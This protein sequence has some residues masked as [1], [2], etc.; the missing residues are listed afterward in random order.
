MIKSF[1]EFNKI[2]ES[3]LYYAPP[4]RQQL[5]ILKNK[6]ESS[7]KGGSDI[8]SKLLELEM[9]D[10]PTDITF[11]NSAEDVGYLT[12]HPM[13]KAIEKIRKTYSPGDDDSEDP[14]D[15]QNKPNKKYHDTIYNN[16]INGRTYMS[17][18]TGNKNAVKIGKFIKK[19][20][21]TTT[22][23]Q[24][25]E[26]VN[27]LKA[28]QD[29]LKEKIEL[30]S[31]DEIAKWY[32]SENCYSGGSLGSSCMKDKN[33]FD[34]YI[35]NPETVNL[36]IM[37]S[38]DKIVSRALVWKLKTTKPQL[39]FTYYMDRVYTNKDYQEYV[40]MAFAEKQGWAYRKSGGVYE[41]DVM[42]QGKKH[43][44]K[45]SVQIKKLKYEKYPYMDTFSRYDYVTGE[46][47]NDMNKN[48]R[49]RGHILTSTQGDFNKG[50]ERGLVRR[51]GDYFGLDIPAL[52][53]D[54]YA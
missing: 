26:F 41:R 35:Q 4:F 8:A 14:L 42:Y 11:V 32:K 52:A 15:I 49:T 34:I 38:G 40:M 43:D 31:G 39:G 18:Y 22:D 23:A 28:V 51:W 20:L 1:N 36:L 6:W 48:Q 29:N 5:E 50:Y 21:P 2:D 45:M 19:V 44:I 47:W 53:R 7:E 17:I 30:V 12:F 25:E 3:V 10:L 54:P 37:K 9:E 13:A 16:E 24:I 27:E 33:F 46:L